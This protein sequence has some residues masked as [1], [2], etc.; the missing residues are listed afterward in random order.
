ME[1]NNFSVAARKRQEK[2]SRSGPLRVSVFFALSESFERYGKKGGAKEKGERKNGKR[3]SPQKCGLRFSFFRAI[4]G[5]QPLRG[6]E[7]LRYFP[8]DMPITL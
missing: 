5:G 7:T 8:G 1:R 2:K 4:K 3:R 6:T